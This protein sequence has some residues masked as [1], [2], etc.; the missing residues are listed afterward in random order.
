MDALSRLLTLNDPQGSIDKNCL[1]SRDWQLPHAAGELSV[2]RWHTVTQGA[3]QLDLPDGSSYTLHPGAVV[4]LAQNS[5]HRLC[6]SGEEQTHLVC[7]SLRL[8]SSSRYFL[9][10]LPELLILAPEE[11]SPVGQW[12]RAMIELL[13]RESMSTL[14][15]SEVVCS[16][17]CATL[18]TL[19][20]REWLTRAAPGKNMLNLLLHPKLGVIANLMLELPAHPWTVEELAQRAHMSRASFAQL[21][22][23]VSN[24]TPLA[25]LTTLR[26]QFAAQMLARDSRPLIVIAEAVGYASESSFH[27]VFLREYGCTPGEYRKRVKALEK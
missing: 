2:I 22:R 4:M 5:A 19:A 14:P 3:A 9:T 16:Q 7:G 6:Q 17:Q 26:L 21:F 27:K 25:V 20:V 24:S 15:G 18:F 11:N 1:L 12:L 8:Q 23:E 13:Q 10:A